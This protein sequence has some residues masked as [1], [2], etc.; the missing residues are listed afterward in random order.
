MLRKKLGEGLSKLIRGALS[1]G[2]GFT[3][4]GAVTAED[5]RGRANGA[6][7]WDKTGHHRC[8]NL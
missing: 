8:P 7:S 6:I 3:V 1:C 5:R 4:E 2:S